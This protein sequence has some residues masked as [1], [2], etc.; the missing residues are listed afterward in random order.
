M[1]RPCFSPLSGPIWLPPA[2]LSPFL[3]PMNFREATDR[4]SPCVTQEAIAAAAGVTRNTIKR[5]RISP[6]SEHFRAPP[7]GWR[8][9][10]ARLARERARDLANVADE[11]DASTNVQDDRA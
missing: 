9:I 11:L 2:D 10:L 8:K 6:T 5:A 4:L 1:R 3:V 7:Q